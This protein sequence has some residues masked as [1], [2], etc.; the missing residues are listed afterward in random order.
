[1][2]IIPGLA[3]PKVLPERVGL[4]ANAVDIPQPL[5]RPMQ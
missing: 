5:V 3:D 4:M 2:I 1:M